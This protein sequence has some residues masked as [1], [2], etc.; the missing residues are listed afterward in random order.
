MVPTAF[1][2]T[3]FSL[4]AI[5]PLPT[6]PKQA[7]SR[8]ISLRRSTTVPH[9]DGVELPL[10]AHVRWQDRDRRSPCQPRPRH[11][12]WSKRTLNQARLS[13]EF[14]SRHFSLVQRGN[15]AYESQLDLPGLNRFRRYARVPGL[16]DDKEPDECLEFLAKSTKPG[17]LGRLGHYESL[18][19]VGRGGMGIVFRA[20]DEK[21]HRV[22][23]IKALAPALAASGVA[24]QRFAREA[25][26]SAA[27]S[28]ENVIAICAVEDSDTV[29]FFVMQFIDGRSL[30]EKLDQMGALPLKEALRIALHVAEGLGAAHRQGLVHRDVLPR[31][32]CSK[33]ARNASSLRTSDW[34]ESLKAVMDARY[35]YLRMLESYLAPNHSAQHAALMK[36]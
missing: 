9:T 32:S 8:R 24:R 5:A 13:R 14:L 34:R 28:H 1:V 20:F 36:K 25:R 15:Q 33:T 31:T 27:V 21:L 23:A 11:F 18:E 4:S 10:R 19:V 29:S 12:P 30:H 3:V 16:P 6:G 35:Q 26:A 17:S 7:R 2:R 22:V